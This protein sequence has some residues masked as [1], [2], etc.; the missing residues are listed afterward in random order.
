M[1]VITG[2]AAAGVGR[3]KV[4]AEQ[5]HAEPGAGAIRKSG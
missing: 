4:V 3:R 2:V 1:L 5:K